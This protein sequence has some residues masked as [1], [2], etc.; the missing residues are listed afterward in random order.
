M[1]G[2]LMITNVMAG[3]DCSNSAY[4]Q[5]HPER[6]KYTTGNTTETFLA[7]GAGAI[8]AGGIAALVGLAGG[9]SSSSSGGDVAQNSASASYVRTVA[10]SA[11]MRTNVGGDINVAQLENAI[12]SNTYNRNANQYDDIQLAYSIARG[13]TGVGTK[14]AV[15]DTA[16]DTRIKTHA[17]YVMDTIAPIAPAATVEHRE[18]AYDTDKFFSYAEIGNVIAQTSGANVYNNS[19]NVSG[20]SADA[21]ANRRQLT[22]LTS[23]DFVN[24]IS[25]AATQNDAIFVWAAGNDSGVQ[26]GMLSAMPNVMSELNGHFVNVV[27]WDSETSSLADYSNACGVTQNYCITAP[28]TIKMTN[29]RTKMGTSFAAP[30]V[31]AAIAVIREAWNYLPADQITQILFDTATDLGEAGVDE[32]YGHGMLDLEAATR[33]VGTPTIQLSENV[34]QPLQVARVSASVAHNIK[35]ANPTMAF[36]DKYGRDFQTKLGDNVSA[37]NRGLGFERMRGDDARTKVNFGDMEFGF[38]RN[39]MLSGTGFLQT[40]G[41]TTTTYIATNKSYNFGDVELFGRSQFG[42][43]RPQVTEQ[44]VISSFSNIYTASAYIGVRG[45]QWSLSVGMPDTIVNGN[46]NLHL[47]TGRNGAGVTTYR[48]YT[49]NMATTPAIEYTANWRFVT[50]GF[51]DNPYG[52]NEFYVFAKTKM[53]F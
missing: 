20:I 8:A 2:A 24:A 52:E 15:F 48:D 23:P 19:W 36:F 47:A 16:L 28:G 9:G 1:C 22:S 4:K 7:V 39:D 53:S 33:P 29:G 30:V 3:D 18:I 5:E 31:S 17:E 32:I 35:S 11:I 46:M 45:N 34:S 27:A 51:V 25:Y 38:Y 13:Y 44:S 14:I 50:A 40:N 26:S 43:A 21:I 10:P 6:C 42:I 49:I 41:D 12:S 37:H